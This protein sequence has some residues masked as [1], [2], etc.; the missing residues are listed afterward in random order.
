M[1]FLAR[2]G[3]STL[4]ASQSPLGWP[5]SQKWVVVADESLGW[6]PTGPN[7]AQND[8]AAVESNP[9][10]LAILSLI[11]H[12]RRRKGTATEL[13]QKL[14]ERFPTLT[15]DSHRFPRSEAR[16]GAALR[17]VQ[18]VLRRRRVTVDLVE[19]GKLAS[20]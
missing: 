3:G 15:E 13:R 16:F 4:R 20:G 10:A 8:Q 11:E 19:R 9:V 14:R 1:P 17:R 2:S 18:P 6:T 5:T 7:R 12:E